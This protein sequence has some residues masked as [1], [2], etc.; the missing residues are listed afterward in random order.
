VA[1]LSLIWTYLTAMGPWWYLPM[2]YS[3]PS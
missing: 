2:W 3:L 1:S